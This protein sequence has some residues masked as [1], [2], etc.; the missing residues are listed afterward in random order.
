MMGRVGGNV[1][2]VAGLFL[3]LSAGSAWGQNVV[4]YTYDPLGRLIDVTY[5]DGAKVTN[6]YD[7]ADNRTGIAVTGLTGGFTVEAPA[8]PAVE[9]GNLVFTVRRSGLIGVA[10]TI[11]V[12]TVPAG[13]SADS[14][15]D[16]NPVATT[17]LTFP[18]GVSSLPVTVTTIN[19]HDVEPTN[20]TVQLQLSNAPVGSNI[21]HEAPGSSCRAPCVAPLMSSGCIASG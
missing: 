19:D 16:Y 18:I 9:G 13:G 6:S 14:G 4:A 20:E 10:Q 3:A 1:A 11:D 15:G 21:D 7:P 17:I 2:W 12:A 8:A 5:A